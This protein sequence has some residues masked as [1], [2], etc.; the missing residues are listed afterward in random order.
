MGVFATKK[1]NRRCLHPGNFLGWNLKITCLGRKMIFFTI[2]G[3]REFHDFLECPTIEMSGIRIG[4]LLS[5]LVSLLS[6]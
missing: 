6:S 3:R 2:P 4:E 5:S 1:G